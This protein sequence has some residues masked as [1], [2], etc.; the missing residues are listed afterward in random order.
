[1]DS[2]DLYVV[3]IGASAGGLDAIQQL[4]DSIPSNTGLAFVVIQHLSPDFKSL[5]P[6]LLAKHTK[7]QIFTA[8]DKQELKPDCIYLNQRNKNLHL[9][10]NK[11]YLLDKG[12]KHNLNLPIDIFFHTL[13][14]EYKE[15]SI[16]VI[17]SGTG[18][19][20]SRGIKTIKE[21]GGTIIVQD[22]NS[23]Q[24]D[25][26]PNTATATNLVDFILD[27]EKMAEVLVKI[28]G[29]RLLLDSDNEKTKSNDVVFF[30]I[31]EE[32]HKSSGIDFRQYKRNTLLRRLEKRMNINNIDQLYDYLTYLKSNSE[33]KEIL[34]QDFLI[35]VTSFFRDIEAFESLKTKVIPELFKNK[36]DKDPI[37]V[38]AA[39]CSTGEEVFSIAILL[40]DYIRTNKI[41]FDF[42]IFA[43]DVDGEA[44]S[45]AGMGSFHINISNELE[46][47]YLENYFVKTGDKIQIAKR[48][49]EKI[50]FSNHNVLKDPPF[51]RMDL[52]TCRNL[53]IYLESKVQRKVLLNFQFALNKFGYLFLGNSE[54]LGEIS[55]FFKV[56]DNKWKIFQNIS[57]TK[58]IPTQSNP[59]DKISTLSYKSPIRHIAQPEYRFKENPEAIFQKYL[60][61]RFS[62]SS[63]FIDKDFNIIYLKGNIS[64]R[65]RHTDGIFVSNLLKMVSP[66]LAAILRN[67]IRRLEA[68]KKDII[69]KDIVVE[70]KG[71]K[72]MF[73]L[74]F[75]KATNIDELNNIYLVHFS[76]ERVLPEDYEVVKNV[77][78]D[79]V[80]KQR[81]EDLENEL[82]ATKTE[83]QNVV[84]ELE[85]SN[86]E[87][88]SSNEE[89]MASNEELQST[90]EELQ[91]VNEELYTVNSE[92]QEKNKELQVLN[93]DVTNLLDS[94]D[95][96]TLFLD[97]D[98]R[99]RK[100]TPPL[101]R[102]FNL[103]DSDIGRPITS[104][105]STF[106]EATR[107]S[108][109]HD[110][111]VALDKLTTI[112][113]EIEDA[114]GN[115]YLK[116][117]S[118]FITNDK[119]IDGVVIT[120]VEITELKEKE[121][122]IVEANQRFEIASEATGIAFWEWYPQEDRTI[123]N[124]KW[125][126]LFGFGG[127]GNIKEQWIDFMHPDDAK[128]IPPLLEAHLK[129]ETEIYHVDFRYNHPLLKKQLWIQ[130]TAKVTEWDDKGNA[131]KLA[132][133]SL[134]ITEKMQQIELLNHEKQFTDKV[135]QTAPAGIYV[136]NLE[137]GINEY[138]NSRY[139]EILGYSKAE[140]NAMTDEEFF[141][142]F[143]LKDQ[144]K[145][146]L[147]MKKLSQGKNDEIEYRFRHKNG[148]WIWCKSNDA[149]FEVD[150]K[151]KAK[152]F[153]GAF[154]DI[155]ESKEREKQLL[156][157]QKAIDSSSDAI[158]L[159]T[160]DGKHF[161]Q[162]KAFDKLF[163]Y[164]LGDYP[165]NSAKVIYHNQK[166]ADTVFNKIMNGNSWVGEL[167]MR[168][169]QGDIFP[170]SLRADAIKD[171][172]GTLIGLIG[173]HRDISER[174][175]A[176]H[177]KEEQHEKTLTMFDAI[178]EVV[179]VADPDTYELVFTNKKFNEI[180]GDGKV[181][182]D[183]KCHQTLQCQD[184][185]CE[186]CTNNIIFNENPDET[187]IWEFQNKANGKWYR[188][189]D[190]A[191]EWIDGRK[192]RM[193]MAIDITSEKENRIALEESQERYNL[194]TTA[195]DNGIWDW[196]V[197]KDELFYSA[198]WKAQ[199]G[200]KPN[201]LK[202]EFKTWENLLHPDCRERMMNEV[203]DFLQNPREFFIAEFRMMHKDGTPRWISNRA[204]AVLNKEGK[205][206]RMFGA[207]KDI[208]EQKR[209][210]EELRKTDLMYR[211]II[212]NAPDGVV[213][214]SYDGKFK[215]ASNSALE[216]FGYDDEL[217]KNGNPNDLTHPDDL[218]KVL[219]TLQQVIESESDF[220]PKLQY[221]FKHGKNEWRWIES[222]FS[223]SADEDGNPAIVI[224]FRD[225]QERKEYE[226]KL[227][228]AKKQAEL[229]NFH[230]NY[231]LAN[232][233]HE[234]RTPMNGVIGFSDLLKNEN[235]SH[236]ERE[237]YINIIDGNS[238]Q[239]LN[240]IDDIIDVAKIESDE[241]KITK[242][243]CHISKIM[244]ELETL[245]NQIKTQKKKDDL[246]FVSEIPAN[247]ESLIIKTD[248]SR[249]RQVLSNLLSNALK[250]TET[251]TIKFGFKINEDK[252]HFY[253]QD[254]GIGIPEE[255][256]S[257]IFERF[258]QV[259]YN[260]VARYG[261]TGLG[262]A[263]CKGIVSYLGGEIS[264][265]SELN[266]GAVF[267]FYL[268]LEI[269]EE[270]TVLKKHSVVPTDNELLKNK[271][272]LI[273]EDDKIVQLYFTE[274]LKNKG[275]KLLIA[276]DGLSAV[277]QFKNNQNINLVLMDIRM[278]KLNG[279]EAIK[280]ILELNP[281][282]KIIAQ[283]AYAMPDEKEKC[284]ELG[285]KAYLTK[286]IQKTTLFETLQEWI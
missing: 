200:Y 220:T 51:I 132:G 170:V 73:D 146:A 254:T 179:Y 54:S 32:I 163:G 30:G 138:T 8:E 197:E 24:F 55:K 3:G 135:S 67:G 242:K 198:Q 21:A 143:H 186:F 126:E 111:K 61:N 222:T 257:E 255:K 282:A 162:N 273:A 216:M 229:A 185:P 155:T 145:I 187:Y 101:M 151:G 206:I 114:E 147:H 219:E 129:G 102:H 23:A 85:T 270:N 223:K 168:N 230:K 108:I 194:A 174:K 69:I 117:I 205:V 103:H 160:A 263:I 150:E 16:G 113:K 256:Q 19:D 161:Y 57:D 60:S 118:P 46:K 210:E 121:K 56:V 5:M 274:L 90:N 80:S 244:L 181:P 22:P 209:A 199:L 215:F 42:K 133:V 247:S 94:T 64:D 258:K 239:L 285:C 68:E 159:S 231:F 35:G 235:L 164:T 275:C 63:I 193:E 236:D 93:N 266:Q 87:L 203:Q 268:P 212:E 58:Q 106:T 115:Y 41:N 283:T 11:L 13:G 131:I 77:P 20:G 40:D 125:E 59:E 165:N 226:E 96:G 156:H 12:P 82:K 176:E 248:C 280:Q 79:E 137:K 44:L 180:W 50:V 104:F 171:D 39:G 184:F 15:K 26:M 27:P 281:E 264:V 28:P 201:E 279:F 14:E 4:F 33:E 233:S 7:M 89:L 49:R 195:S 62:P 105:A 99:I 211:G 88:Q 95:I 110:S 2:N 120:F 158:G 277:E 177:I 189:A 217:V 278:P 286:P 47:Y 276:E 208:T 109:I 253:V 75:H 213:M 128:T 45:S 154:L 1:M 140:M 175:K 250:F 9:K 265:K 74:T 192:L 284:M 119:K 142:L 52:I 34:K 169:K 86:E 116:R 196:W 83:L 157:F 78:I 48:I 261:G 172:K 107:Q 130:S 237:H 10:G 183:K 166:A 240:L 252:V 17:L 191:I 71:E 72:N 81:L 112:E 134:D 251:G 98:L 36:T 260:E 43:T 259:N 6:E 65:L 29:Q 18:S 97:T 269:M 245:F 246:V 238:K 136:Y 53:L 190:R 153:I 225:I 84:E 38:W 204:A 272:I 221:R 228:E 173:M 144:E 262:L 76:E 70:N 167:E 267:S 234:L 122:D 249:L 139:E 91:S 243:A 123:G 37:R 232:M 188:C 100:F 202:N 218:P 92:L 182:A 124:A 227:I 66:E 224:N 31:L 25:G 152:S 127:N 148:N 214:V 149:P 178:D 271:T 207:H 241:L 141:T